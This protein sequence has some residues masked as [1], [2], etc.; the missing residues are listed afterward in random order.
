M[1]LMFECEI[2]GRV[3]ILKNNK[4]LIR[5]RGR[6]IPISSDRFKA[7]E[8]QAMY[9]VLSAKPA[10][11]ISVPIRLECEF[12]FM[13]RKSLPDLSNCYQGVEDLLQKACVIVNDSQ[14]ESHAGSARLISGSEKTVVRIF[15]YE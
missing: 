4:K 6:I 1:G 15:E 9:Y 12:H 8:K 13:N 2:P 14:V 7:W 10:G 3:G 11:Q 5:V